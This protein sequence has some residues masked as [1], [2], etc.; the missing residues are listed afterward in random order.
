MSHRVDFNFAGSRAAVIHPAATVREELRS[1][2]AVL[3]LEAQ[4]Q[5]PPEPDALKAADVIFVDVDTGHDEL[6]PW[7]PGTAPVQ[8]IGLV[9]SEAPGRLAWALSY[10]VDAYMPVAAMGTVYSTLV[11]AS[12][13]RGE[14]L[15]RAERRRELHRRNG[16]RHMLVRAVLHIMQHEGTDEINALKHLR[17]R[18]MSDRMS[19]EDVAVAVLAEGASGPARRSR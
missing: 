19:L 14:R 15:E 3:G 10:G 4:G 9:R 6:F 5:W 8:V 11:V 12:A 17:A 18:A 2:L 1:R 16:L 13:H 7:L